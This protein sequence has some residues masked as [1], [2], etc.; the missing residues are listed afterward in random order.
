MAVI[1]GNV[2]AALDEASKLTDDQAT[3][4]SGGVFGFEAEE[5]VLVAGFAV[6]VCIE[7]ACGV[8]FGT[9]EEYNV[10][11]DN[12]EVIDASSDVDRRVSGMDKL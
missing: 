11:E 1:I 6:H 3:F 12:V 2:G 8:P 9:A 5:E 4:A 10:Q 7:N